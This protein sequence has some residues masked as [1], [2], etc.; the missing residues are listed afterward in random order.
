GFKT[1]QKTNLNLSSAD[2][3]AIGELRLEVGTLT[4]T[5]E[6]TASGAAIQTESSER[7]ALIDSKQ[8]TNLMAKGRDVMSLLQLLPGAVDDNTGSETLGQFSIPT[9]GGT[10][11]AYSA[12]NVD[13]I[14]G[15]TARGRTA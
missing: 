14:S 3:L 11:P 2:R 1:F 7:S 12:L 6:V 5:V 10:R 8:I 4:E 15:N 9:M 13:G